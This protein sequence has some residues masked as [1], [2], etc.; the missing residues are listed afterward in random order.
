MLPI[1]CL[2]Y[3]FNEWNITNKIVT[4][5]SDSEANIK[6]A[7]NEHLKKYHHP[8][9]AHTLNLSVND[10][11]N[12]NTELF[13]VLKTCRAIVGHFKHSSTYCK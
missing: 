13:Q 9:V 11:I 4:I 12:K 2:S 6:N 5:V 10:A 3:I 8:C 1:Y 7:I